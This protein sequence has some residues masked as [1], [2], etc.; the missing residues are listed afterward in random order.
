MAGR[1]PGTPAPTTEDADGT[2]A[3]AHA[4]RPWDAQD[5]QRGAAGGGGGRTPEVEA[6]G[7]R[8]ASAGTGRTTRLRPGGARLVVV[9]A[10]P[11]TASGPTHRPTG[12]L[13]GLG[14]VLAVVAVALGSLLDAH[15]S[16][17]PLMQRHDAVGVIAEH[18][19]PVV[20]AHEAVL[21]GQP[22][23][24][25]P[26]YDRTAVGSSVAAET[27]GADFVV[28]SPG[29]AIPA[30]A[31]RLR[32]GLEQRG[33]SLTAWDATNPA[34]A[35][36]RASADFASGASGTVRGLQQDALRINSVWTEVEYPALRANPS[37]T[38][39]VSVDPRTGAEAV[40]WSR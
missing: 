15:A 34:S 24:R 13:V 19:T 37:V 5:G 33:V 7:R 21:P 18:T 23:A 14:L 31:A 36:R 2:S 6:A 4:G 38:R 30:D 35:W 39:I 8:K 22:R 28:D 17:R 25:A 11:T 9:P 40:L 10:G 20:G 1:P 32:A 26:D 29:T 27:G 12:L 3:V 16:A